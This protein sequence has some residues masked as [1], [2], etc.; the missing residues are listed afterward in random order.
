MKPG[1]WRQGNNAPSLKSPALDQ[2]SMKLETACD[3]RSL[4]QCFELVGFL[5]CFDAV[6]QRYGIRSTPLIP[7]GSLLVVV[8]QLKEENG[9]GTGN[10]RFPAKPVPPPKSRPSR[11]KL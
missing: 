10:Q 1:Y 6:G 5:Q 7:K 2:G 8:E 4:G 3:F 11:G 9:G